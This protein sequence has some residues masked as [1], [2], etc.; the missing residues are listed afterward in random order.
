M[1]DA[2]QVQALIEE[3]RRICVSADS[4]LSLLWHRFVPEARKGDAEFRMDVE[5]VISAVRGTYER[6]DGQSLLSRL[7]ASGE[8][9][10][11]QPIATAPKDGRRILILCGP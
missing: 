3:L 7:A 8:G 11:W 9:Q 1:S 4:F 2:E 5:R 10:G 6:R